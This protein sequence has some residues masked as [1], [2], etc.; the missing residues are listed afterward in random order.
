LEHGDRRFQAVEY[1]DAIRHDGL[2]IELA[3]VV[4]GKL[5]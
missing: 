1:H 4:D 5:G 2:A 3:E